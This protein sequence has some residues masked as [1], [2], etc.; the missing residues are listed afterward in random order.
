M[1]EWLVKL[2]GTRTQEEVAQHCE[3]HRG[4]YAL[5]EGGLRTPSVNVAK[6]IASFLGFDWTIFFE[7]E[8]VEMKHN[9]T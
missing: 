4:Y 1:R 7:G 8:R 5:I 9:T 6:Q 3:I 2:R